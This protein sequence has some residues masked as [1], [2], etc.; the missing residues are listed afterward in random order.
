MI[1]NDGDE[2]TD[3]HRHKQ[4]YRHHKQIDKPFALDMLLE[5]IIDSWKEKSLQSGYHYAENSFP[6]I[7]PSLQ[8]R[9]SGL[10]RVF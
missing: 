1:C 6:H 9:R 5:P 2:G 4:N 8:G 7:S 3:N 10:C